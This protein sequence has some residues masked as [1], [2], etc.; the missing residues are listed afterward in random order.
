M[1]R[2]GKIEDPE[3]RIR[4]GKDRR[5]GGAHSASGAGMPKGRSSKQGWKDH[6]RPV[7]GGSYMV[8]SPLMVSRKVCEYSSGMRKPDLNA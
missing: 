7:H 2:R 5:V 3:P 6:L 1:G 4:G 8:N